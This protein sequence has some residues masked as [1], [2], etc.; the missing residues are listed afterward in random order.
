MS[1]RDYYRDFG[2]R[3]RREQGGGESSN[4]VLSRMGREWRSDRYWHWH[5]GLLKLC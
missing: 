5:R 2:S 3:R 1:R 4:G